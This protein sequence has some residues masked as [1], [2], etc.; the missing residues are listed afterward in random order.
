MLSALGLALSVVGAGALSIGLFRSLKPLYPGYSRDPL[1]AV[2]RLR[3]WNHRLP[4]SDQRL[5]RAGA[6]HVRGEGDA[7]RPSRR[8]RR[9]RRARS[10]RGPGVAH[11]RGP[12]ASYCSAA[13]R[14]TQ[15]GHSYASRRACGS[16]QGWS[17]PEGGASRDSGRWNA[18]LTIRVATSRILAA[19]REDSDLYRRAPLTRGD[20]R[21]KCG[22]ERVA[23]PRF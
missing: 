20:C 16:S 2:R 1:Q 11:L 8:N 21:G 3:V 18:R 13:R 4:F 10:R 15:N 14:S 9:R 22:S 6:P 5:R 12:N 7:A 19:R 23:V 17:V